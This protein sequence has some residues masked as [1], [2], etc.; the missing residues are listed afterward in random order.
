MKTPCETIVWHVLPVIRKEF[1]KN[2]VRHHGFTQRKIALRLGIS[3]AAVSRY[4][5]GTRGNIVISNKKILKEIVTSSGIIA[6]G[7]KKTVTQET[8]RICSFLKSSG[9][10]EG[11]PHACK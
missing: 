4:I 9:F 10:L 1:A 6:N 7:N 11:I 2:L 3:D 8:C 5:A